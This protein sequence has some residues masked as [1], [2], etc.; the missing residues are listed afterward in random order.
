MRLDHLLSRETRKVPIG[1]EQSS[2]DLEDNLRG[3]PPRSDMLKNSQYP[4]P[5]V[6]AVSGGRTPAGHLESCIAF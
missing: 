6:P 3:I 4:A 2:S 1:V 5:R